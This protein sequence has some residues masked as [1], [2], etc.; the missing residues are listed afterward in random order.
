MPNT[1]IAGIYDIISV[2]LNIS[3]VVVRPGG[4]A[5]DGAFTPKSDITG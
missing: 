4:G 1:P 5:S 2:T 3:F